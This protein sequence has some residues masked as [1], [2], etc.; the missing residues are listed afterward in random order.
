MAN[1]YPIE[2]QLPDGITLEVLDRYAAQK[3][4]ER[5]KQYRDRHPEKM[6]QQRITSSKNLLARNGYVVV[7]V[8]S[9][10]PLPDFDMES[11]PEPVKAAMKK[12]PVWGA[13]LITVLCYYQALQAAQKAVILDA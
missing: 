1:G 7:K 3:E 8:G 10:D 12:Y 5:R 2:K 13:N 9:A 11:M 4:R 6:M